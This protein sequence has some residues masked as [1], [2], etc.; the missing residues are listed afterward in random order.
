MGG[1]A[2]AARVESKEKATLSDQAPTPA[3]GAIL[4]QPEDAGPAPGQRRAPRLSGP[5]LRAFARRHWLFALALLA[6]AVPRVVAMLGFQPAILFRMDSYDYLWGAVHVSPDLVNPSGYSL[7]LW[8]LRPLHSLAAV[9]AVQHLLGLGIATMA[10]AVLRRHGLPAWGATLGAAPALFEPALMLTETLVMADLLAMALMVAGLAALLLRESPSPGRSAAAGLL[11]GLSAVV[12][13]TTLPLV[14]AIPVFL[15]LRRVGWRR[16]GAALVAGALP[17]L[18]YVGW[19][20]AVHGSFNM[21]QSNGLFLWSRTMSFA[22]CQVIKPP[23][24]LRQLCPTAQHGFL[25]QADPAKRPPPKWYLWMPGLSWPWWHAAP[26]GT[27]PDKIPFT[28]A[29]NGRAL[30]FAVLA[31]RAQPLAYASTVG[32]E[33]LEPFTGNDSTLH[34]PGTQQPFVMDGPHL[35]YA[36]AAVRG[37][38]G[39]TEGLAPLVRSGYHFTAQ[40]DEP[41]AYLMREYQH[42][43][44]LPG[45]G[46]GLIALT[47]LAGIAIPRRRSSAAILLWL[48]A[49]VILVLPIAEHEYAYRYALPAVPLFAMAAALA[50]R[51]PGGGERQTAG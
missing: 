35:R 17:V 30:R 51:K 14:I 44:F 7:F 36:L 3:E 48:S 39:S 23:T 20:A 32:R 22:D 28:A 34:F 42:L 13:P 26:P 11:M 6:A 45:L 27:V 50:F 33:T 19:F 15:L 49:A 38:T 9:A 31:I 21:S 18:G 1:P 8:L 25:A 24:D 37:Y 12:R 5:V 46:L 4:S 16:A 41:Y 29:N 43:I 47:G 10:Y 40:Q 2:R